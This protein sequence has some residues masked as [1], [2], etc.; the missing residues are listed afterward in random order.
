MEER[1]KYGKSLK[2][3]REGVWM[4]GGV[5]FRPISTANCACVE[6]GAQSLLRKQRTAARKRQSVD[7]RDDHHRR[8]TISVVLSLFLYIAEVV[9][10]SYSIFLL[11]PISIIFLIKS[12]NFACLYTQYAER[13]FFCK[14]TAKFLNSRN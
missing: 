8:V 3:C 5:K 2:Q 13:F 14:H 7:C 10:I 6:K 1:K 11:A 4:S 12:I 9:I